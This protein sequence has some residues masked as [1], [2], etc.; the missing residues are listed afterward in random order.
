[1]LPAHGEPGVAVGWQQ[2]GESPAPG[3]I[4]IG[5]EEKAKK[6]CSAGTG[7]AVSIGTVSYGA[8]SA[9]TRPQTGSDGVFL[10]HRGARPGRSP[11]TTAC[12]SLL[13][14]RW[15]VIVELSLVRL[16]GAVDL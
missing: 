9:R 12:A 5:V 16:A 10:P 15:T 2:N 13:P 3:L 11:S 14:P 8:D 7:A 4:R 1:M 6:E